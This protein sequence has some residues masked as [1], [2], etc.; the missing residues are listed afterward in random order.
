MLCTCMRV[1]QIADF[2]LYPDLVS[3]WSNGVVKI[4]S[5]GGG[6]NTLKFIEQ[7]VASLPELCCLNLIKP[8][9]SRGNLASLETVKSWSVKK[10]T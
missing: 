9:S 3:V 1:I 10:K 2:L 8:V 4:Q 5:F 6:I 7:L